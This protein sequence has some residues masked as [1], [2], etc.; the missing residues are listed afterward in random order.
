M[1]TR[2]EGLQID[3]I[4]PILDAHMVS[5]SCK[6][7]VSIQVVRDKGEAAK[8]ERNGGLDMEV[9]TGI[10]EQIIVSSLGIRGRVMVFKSYLKQK[11]CSSSAAKKS[12]DMK[13][14]QIP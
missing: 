10:T 4:S 2:A 3:R 6:D 11:S 9:K 1:N 7:S 13:I 8:S 5:C 14:S 12:R